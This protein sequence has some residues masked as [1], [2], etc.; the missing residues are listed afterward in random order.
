[1]AMTYYYLSYSDNLIFFAFLN[2]SFLS[3]QIPTFYIQLNN[4]YFML[5]LYNNI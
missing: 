4:S 5:L 1:M 2:G 3:S